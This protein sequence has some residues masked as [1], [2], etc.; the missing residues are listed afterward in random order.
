MCTVLLPPAVNPIAFNKYIISYHI[1]LLFYIL[2]TLIFPFSDL[3][4]P[5]N[6]RC[7]GVIV[8]PDYTQTH[9]RTHAHTLGRTPLDG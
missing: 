3:F 1:I 2:F 7:A 4:V 6:F 8:A 9:T 5:N